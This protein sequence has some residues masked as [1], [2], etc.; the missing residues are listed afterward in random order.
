MPA[1]TCVSTCPETAGSGCSQGCW[2][3]GT[4][5]PTSLATP[6]YHLCSHPHQPANFPLWEWRMQSKLDGDLPLFLV[7][8][9]SIAA[10][11]PPHPNPSPPPAA[12]SFSCSISGLLLCQCGVRSSSCCL[13]KFYFLLSPSALLQG[14]GTPLEAP[15]PVQPFT[16]YKGLLRCLCAPH[17]LTGEGHFPGDGGS[18]AVVCCLFA[19][20]GSQAVRCLS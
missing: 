3:P 6:V 19:L 13:E 20:P 8:E 17:H 14:L 1:C 4:A 18:G 12:P 16:V 7:L 10:S 9:V 2:E 5:W 11:P 15:L